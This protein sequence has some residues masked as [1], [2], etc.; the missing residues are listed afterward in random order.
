MKQARSVFLQG[1]LLQNLDRI[2]SKPYIDK[3]F[4]YDFE[5]WIKENRISKLQACLNFIQ[6]I[7]SNKNSIAECKLWKTKMFCPCPRSRGSGWC[8][9]MV[10][11]ISAC[12]NSWFGWVWIRQNLLVRSFPHS[13]VPGKN[14]ASNRGTPLLFGGHVDYQLLSSRD[15]YERSWYAARNKISRQQHHTATLSSS[16]LDFHCNSQL[17]HFP[18]A[19]KLVE[20]KQD[21][22]LSTK[23]TRLERKLTWDYKANLTVRT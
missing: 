15:E 20:A 14:E 18:M 5:N 8:W 19:E 10:Q 16:F 4:F 6:C 9:L 7:Q 13:L 1:L 12:K 3:K 23:N 21:D 2:Q 11:F 22:V 17:V